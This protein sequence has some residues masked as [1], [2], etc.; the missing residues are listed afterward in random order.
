MLPVE[1]LNGLVTFVTTARA[2]TFTEAAETLGLSRSAVGKA[3]ARLEQ[4]LGVRLFH[5]TTRRIAL[6]ADGQ[7]YYASCAAA[8]EEI[9]SAEACLGSASHLPAGRLRIDM[10]SSFGRQVMLPVLL[11][12]CQQHPELQLTL[13]FTDHFVDPAEE[14]IDLLIRFGGLDQAQ[15]LVARPLGRQ[16]LITCA[17]PS[18]LQAHGTPATVEALKTHRSIV[19]FRHGQP[20]AWRIGPEAEHA[21]F[22]PS[23]THQLSDGDAVI[24]AAI[25]GLGICQMPAFL[26]RRHLASGAL[27]VVLPQCVP[28]F[29]EIHALWPQT[30]HLRPKV[31][32]V[33]DELT[34]L[35]EAGAFD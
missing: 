4:R 9:A 19:G 2:S 20:V 6:T 25:A 22:I 5:R 33:V 27:R 29:V 23:G 35:A 21:P 12:I 24:E 28:Q 3:I 31:R 14:G 13:T 17:A 30:R 11:R 7:A 8:L 18:Y 34:R 32:H 15:H 16:R 1:S 26:V 10:P